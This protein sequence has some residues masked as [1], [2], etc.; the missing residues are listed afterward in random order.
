MRLSVPEF[1]FTMQ[2]VT[3]VHPPDKRVLENIHLSFYPG[4]KIGVIGANGSGKSSLLR[5]MAG[6]DTT[7]AGEAKP[8]PGT[9]IGYFAQEPDL[10]AAKTV[11]DAVSEGVQETQALITRFE[12]IS[13]KLGEPM[14][15]DAMTDA[16]RRAGVAAGQDRRGRR[17]EPR[18]PRRARDGRAPR[19]AEGRRDRAP[20]RRR[21]APRRALPAPPLAPGHAAPRRAD[22]PPRRRV[23]R[24]ARALPPRVPGHRRRGHARSLLPRQRRR[25]DPRARSRARLPVRG[26][27]LRLARAE[28]RAPRAGGEAG[29]GAPAQAEAGARV[30]ARLDR[31]RARPRARRVSRRTTRSS[32][33]RRRARPIR[34]E[35]SHP[36][37]AAPRRRRD[38]GQRSSKKGF[39]DRVSDRRPLVPPAARGIVGVIG[40]NGA[41]KTT[42]FKMLIGQEKPDSGDAQARRDGEDLLRRS[43]ARR[44]RRATRASGRSSPAATRPSSS[45]SAR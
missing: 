43:V 34:R 11:W 21:E 22:Q 23:G 18:P 42:L 20:L 15:D 24:L 39:G 37:G 3:K 14:D 12:E 41:G 5:I 27:L 2:A 32:P 6:V 38:R 8:H 36:A 25:V 28:V 26:Q 33:S 29:V 44:A 31:A 7:F 30:G 40:P 10:G 16:A 9:R 19:A 35:I 1:I 4:A 17:V 45:A 13:N